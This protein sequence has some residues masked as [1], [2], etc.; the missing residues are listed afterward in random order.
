MRITQYTTQMA[1]EVAT[2]IET[3]FA[4]HRGARPAQLLSAP[5]PWATREELLPT[6]TS[7]ALCAKA[8]HV[9]LEGERVVSAALALRSGEEC[10]WWRIATAPDHRR[11]GLAR[12][13][14]EAGESAMRAAGQASVRTETIVDSRWTAAGELLGALGY[15][16]EDPERRN[17]T[18]VAERWTPRPVALQE[19]YTLG[20]WREED[21]AEWMAV[22]NAVFGG[23]AGTEWFEQRFLSRPDFDPGTWL[24][25]RHEGAI[26]GI[27]SAVCVEHER[28]PQRLRGGQI[29]WVGVLDAH[30][31]KRLG[32]ELVVACLNAIAERGYL[33]A[34]LLTQPFRVPAV[35]LY[36]KL[37][38]ATIAAWQRWGKSLG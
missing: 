29:E 26:I 32:E 20:T 5:E 38:F 24:V 19:G 16:L 15:E 27:A 14:V 34:L 6:L 7:D 35:K 33:P 12:A 18:M 2:L 37:G 3:C 11:N 28:D 22:R 4:E 25:V 21:L 8:S 23:E 36:E 9:A 17:I 30:R 31:G 13:C 10:G 1:D